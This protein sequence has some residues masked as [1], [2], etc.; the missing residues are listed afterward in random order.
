MIVKRVVGI[1]PIAS[2]ID[3]EID[4]LGETGPLDQEP[5]FLGVRLAISLASTSLRWNVS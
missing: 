1:D 2:G 5:A 4:D 3:V